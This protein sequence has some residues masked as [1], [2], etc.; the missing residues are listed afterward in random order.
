M[1][2]P[3]AET[4]TVTE[5]LASSVPVT[6]Y[7]AHGVATPT[8]APWATV[9]EVDIDVALPPQPAKTSAKEPDSTLRNRQRFIGNG[10]L[11]G[12]EL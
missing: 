5:T 12:A 8:I 2:L 1:V 3:F 9:V 7:E 10:T 11:V 4:V 6:K